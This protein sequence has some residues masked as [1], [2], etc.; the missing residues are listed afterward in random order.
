MELNDQDLDHICTR[1]I[2]ASKQTE[3]RLLPDIQRGP[4]WTEAHR[5]RCEAR[6]LM[7]WSRYRRIGYYER[8]QKRRG[9]TYAAQLIA[10][11]RLA[12]EESQR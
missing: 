3:F 1:S 9:E 12:Y 6:M 7:A 4:T 5:M 10:E 11:V 2:S 8:I